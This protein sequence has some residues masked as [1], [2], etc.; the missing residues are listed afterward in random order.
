M[1][2]WDDEPWALRAVLRYIYSFGYVETE[3]H[4]TDWKFHLGV[5]QTAR[6]YLIKNGLKGKALDALSGLLTGMTDMDQVVE[7]MKTLRTDGEDILMAKAEYLENKHI[8]ALYEH[9]GFRTLVEEDKDLM[10]KLL[11]RGKKDPHELAG[12]VEIEWA[13]CTCNW[14]RFRQPG[15][16]WAPCGKRGCPVTSAPAKEHVRSMWLKQK[17]NVSPR[18]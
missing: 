13:R 5:Y 11:N 1:T 12:L 2:L 3:S 10:W 18:I 15:K 4:K 8:N 6:K 16:D 14:R 9:S 7:A 17:A